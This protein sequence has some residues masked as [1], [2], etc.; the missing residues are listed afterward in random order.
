MRRLAVGKSLQRIAIE[1]RPIASVARAAARA[2]G[3][4]VRVDGDGL[5]VSAASADVDAANFL[6]DWADTAIALGWMVDDVF[7]RYGKS[8][9]HR[10]D[11]QRARRE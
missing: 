6:R 3:V 5:I 1:G 11:R 10:I 9:W 2:A 4:R 7:G 8:Q